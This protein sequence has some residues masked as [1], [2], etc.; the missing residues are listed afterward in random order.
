MR[1]FFYV[2][3]M[4]LECNL[5]PLALRAPKFPACSSQAPPSN[6]T[7]ELPRELPQAKSFRGT[8]CV[9]PRAECGAS[10]G[11]GQP[12]HGST[13]K[14]NAAHGNLTGQAQP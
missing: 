14:T 5:L 3:N 12:I 13:P 6:E 11:H 1:K 9:L 7:V 8:F 2:S 4:T 10:F